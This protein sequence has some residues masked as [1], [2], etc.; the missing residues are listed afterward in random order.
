MAHLGQEKGQG[1]E[2]EK[3]EKGVKEGENNKERERGKRK[4]R[5]NVLY[6]GQ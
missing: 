1:Q 4:G 2:L 6:L 3:D 5:R